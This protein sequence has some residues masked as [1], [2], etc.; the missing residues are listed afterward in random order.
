MPE[1]PFVHSKDA[2]FCR[3][4]PRPGRRRIEV[5]EGPG[6]LFMRERPRL[7][8]RWGHWPQVSRPFPPLAACP[9]GWQP[10]H[11]HCLKMP[12]PTARTSAR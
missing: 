5:C 2:P 8:R 10:A 4:T 1:P 9:G 3:A 12:S 6:R 11:G 7:M